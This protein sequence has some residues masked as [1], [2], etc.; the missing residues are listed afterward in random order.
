MKVP[1]EFEPELPEKVRRS[2][3]KDM[4]RN[5]KERWKEYRIE[6]GREAERRKRK[7]VLRWERR[8]PVSKRPK[9]EAPKRTTHDLPYLTSSDIPKDGFRRATI[10]RPPE[11]TETKW[12]NRYRIALEFEDHDKRRWSMNDTTFWNLKDAYGVK[13]LEWV[14]KR[15]KLKVKQFR[16]QEKDVTGIVGEP[17]K[18][19]TA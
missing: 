16:I 18:Q 8:K 9:T 15:I 2:F 5:D 1:P 4:G 19:D 13:P 3:W 10:I 17:V 6:L 14:G 12:G 7:A 11:I